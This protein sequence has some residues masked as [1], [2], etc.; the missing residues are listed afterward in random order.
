MEEH[1]QESYLMPEN[2]EI[3]DLNGLKSF[4]SFLD[5]L[6]ENLKTKVGVLPVVDDKG[7]S[8]CPFAEQLYFQKEEA[9]EKLN[10]HLKKGAQ[11]VDL[12]SKEISK[13]HENLSRIK[14]DR[15]SLNNPQAKEKYE[16]ATKAQ[17]QNINKNIE[18][19]RELEDVI[20]KAT[21]CLRISK[22]SQWPLGK[23]KER[24]FGS[25]NNSNSPKRQHETDLSGPSLKTEANSLISIGPL[26]GRG[27]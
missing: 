10:E 4:I 23:P 20:S 16:F 1:Q 11:Y 6:V 25:S 15:S 3:L 26:S 7:G 9:E 27:I 22:S 21:E 18:Q 19:L 24:G 8:E 12:L 17:K 2:D 5:E 13:G 14:S